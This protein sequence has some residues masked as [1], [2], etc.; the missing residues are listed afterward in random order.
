MSQLFSTLQEAFVSDDATPEEKA[1]T[2]AAQPCFDR[3]CQVLPGREADEI[4]SAAVR[5]GLADAEGRFA[6]GFRLG[7]KLMLEV[8]EE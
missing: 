5:I 4:W 8:L 3:L 2:R 6:A 1:A 7:A